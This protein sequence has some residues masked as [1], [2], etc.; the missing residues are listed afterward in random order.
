MKA[1]LILHIPGTRLGEGPVWD[2]RSRQLWWVDI[3]NGR[4]H[5]FDPARRQD[6]TYEI[7]QFVGALALR[8]EGGL[9]LAL[10]SG[11]AF[12]D[13]ATEQLTPIADP[14][15]DRPGN[16]FNDG[17]CDP[18]GRFWAGTMDHAEQAAS[19]SLYCLDPDGM[20]VSRHLED[21][22]ISNGLAWTKAGDRLY[23]IDSPTHKVQAFHYDINSGAIEYDRDVLTFDPGYGYPDGMC[24]DEEDQLWIAFWDGAK[25]RRFD[26]DRGRQTWQIDVPARRPTSC[27]FGG[28]NLETLFITSAAKEGDPL[29]G[30]LFAV[31]PGLRGVETAL[32]EG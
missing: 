9:L 32:F 12:Y 30:G 6:R 18:A 15:V 27:C 10:Q 8:Q 21:I 22:R 24:I 29:G 17:K 4:I 2:H 28:N 1:A 13:P 5:A 14:E 26:P 31:K 11:F 25:V 16:R 7:G 19:G 23:Y 20:T 3:L